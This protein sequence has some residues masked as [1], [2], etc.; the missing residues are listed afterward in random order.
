MNTQEL[1]ALLAAAPLDCHG[2]PLR[3]V[4]MDDGD[5]CEM[6]YGV[7][8]LDACNRLVDKI[9]LEHAARQQHPLDR[10]EYEAVYTNPQHHELWR[11]SHPTF[12]DFYNLMEQKRLTELELIANAVDVVVLLPSWMRT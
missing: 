11:S 5:V 4:C 9:R 7:M 10:A 6:E 2:Q 1:A 8:K 3:V 12:D